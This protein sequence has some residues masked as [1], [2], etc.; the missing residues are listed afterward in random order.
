MFNQQK[1]KIKQHSQKK[2]KV[3]AGHISY[4]QLLAAYLERQKSV[5]R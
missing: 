4:F 1:Y 3:I 2:R 5:K